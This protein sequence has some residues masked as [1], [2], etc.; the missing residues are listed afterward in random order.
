MRVKYVEFGLVRH[1][2][3]E[4]RAQI[5]VHLVTRNVSKREGEREREAKCS[6]FDFVCSFV[7][8]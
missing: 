1:R 2:D 6:P 4:L 5:A 8:Q 7:K 3:A